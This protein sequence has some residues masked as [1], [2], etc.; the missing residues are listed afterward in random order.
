MGID[1][2]VKPG[3]TSG[4]FTTKHALCLSADAAEE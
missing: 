2:H 3:A 1:I 4:S